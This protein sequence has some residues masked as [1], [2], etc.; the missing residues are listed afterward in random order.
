MCVC[1]CVRLQGALIHTQGHVSPQVR[2]APS[3]S[4]CLCVCAGACVQQAHVHVYTP[5]LLPATATPPL[6][7]SGTDDIGAEESDDKC[8]LSANEADDKWVGARAAPLRCNNRRWMAWRPLHHPYPSAPVTGSGSARPG[9]SRAARL[10]ANHGGAEKPRPWSQEPTRPP[11]AEEQSGALGGSRRRTGSPARLR[12]GHAAVH[13]HGR[14][15][16]LPPVS[17]HR[18]PAAPVQAQPPPHGSTDT[19]FHTVHGH[20]SAPQI[21][22][23]THPH[24]PMHTRQF[25]HA[26]TE[27]TNVCAH[28]CCQHVCT[29]MDTE[30]CTHIS[31]N[32]CT[33]IPTLTLR[34]VHTIQGLQTPPHPHAKDAHSCINKY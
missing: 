5:V 25:V 20:T 14:R 1:V 33:W 11:A 31:K 7:V 3:G 18:A 13:T 4:V 21:Q 30:I 17:L 27:T 16:R 24:K 10:A 9:G 26:P 28:E 6:P 23:H 22:V 34:S 12:P 8:P 2:C 32:A 29:W 19:C 15:T